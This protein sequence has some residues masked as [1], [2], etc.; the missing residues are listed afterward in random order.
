MV[1]MKR[2]SIAALLLAVLLTFGMSIGCFATES[3]VNA[4]SGE[5]AES[6]ESTESAVTTESAAAS[7][8]TE[9]EGGTSHKKFEDMTDEEKA[10]VA[11]RR[12]KAT[13]FW[14]LVDG[15]ISLCENG[16]V[17][18]LALGQWSEGYVETEGKLYVAKVATP[19]AVM[20]PVTLVLCVI[21]SYFVGSVNFGVVV[22]K[23]MCNDDVRN[24]GSGNAGMTNMMRVHGKKAAILTFVGDAGKAAVCALIGLILAGNAGGYLAMTGCMIGHAFP[25]FFKFKGGKGV[26]SLAGGMLVLEPVVALILIAFF[27]IIVLG[28]KYVSLGSVIAGC[29]LPILVDGAWNVSPFHM[30]GSH[31]YDKPIVMICSVFFAVGLVWL[32][33][34]NIKR[35]L[36]GEE[37]KTDLIRDLFKKKKKEEKN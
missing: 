29:L 13:G 19:P 32:H 33:R 15:Y 4:E 20:F 36:A 23:K 24:H 17:V 21:L 5:N 11:I 2:K 7:D 35:L 26:S 30:A 34:S 9:E 6:A 22:S 1:E 16:G 8:G 12:E 31:W 28:T 25:I 3:K 18:T 10:A 27:A 37:R 14:A